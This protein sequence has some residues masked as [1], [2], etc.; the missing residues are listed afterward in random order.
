MVMSMA[1]L[2][3]IAMACPV[4]LTV[5]VT[6][7]DWNVEEL[8]QALEAEVGQ[9]FESVG[10]QPLKA[11]VCDQLDVVSEGSIFTV[12][13][14]ARSGTQLQRALKR[15]PDVF[16]QLVR[17]GSNLCRAQLARSLPELPLST[18]RPAVPPSTV[19]EAKAVDTPMP[20]IRGLF[21]ELSPSMHVGGHLGVA[22]GAMAD[23]GYSF[24]ALR[25]GVSAGFRHTVVGES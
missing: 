9:P 25:L 19:N 14:R 7:V 4:H 21:I 23:V 16:A 17:L 15:S 2:S 10:P 5:R 18:V 13:H 24:G 12:T 20:P 8:R 1:M 22:A 6:D 3:A 11:P